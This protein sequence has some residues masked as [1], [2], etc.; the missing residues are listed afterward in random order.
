MFVFLLVVGRLACPFWVR[1]WSGLLARCS[2]FVSRL[3]APL[4]PFVCL[5]FRVPRFALWLAAVGRLW[6]VLACWP[7]M[8]SFLPLVSCVGALLSVI[9]PSGCARW[10][11]KEKKM[12]MKTNVFPHVH[13]VRVA[14]IIAQKEDNAR[15]MMAAFGRP[16]GARVPNSSLPHSLLEVLTHKDFLSMLYR[17]DLNGLNLDPCPRCRYRDICDPTE[18]GMNDSNLI[19]GYE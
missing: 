18:C 17:N 11:S 14:R 6:L 5:W 13:R 16:M 3:F 1:L 15:R 10:V 9:T 19:E 4:V 7:V 12:N 8:L 2:R